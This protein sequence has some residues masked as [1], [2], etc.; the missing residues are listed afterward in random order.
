MGPSAG[1]S[2]WGL[3]SKRPQPI[4]GEGK[5]LCVRSWGIIFWPAPRTLQHDGMI[6]GHETPGALGRFRSGWLSEFG[7]WD[8][9]MDQIGTVWDRSQ[10]E[11]RI[12]NLI[13]LPKLLVTN[14]K[15]ITDFEIVPSSSALAL[16]AYVVLALCLYWLHRFQSLFNVLRK[17]KDQVRKH[18]FI[19]GGN[20]CSF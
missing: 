14:C 9:T 17:T 10:F 16:M 13:S 15:L 18:M 11:I 7:T 12:S 3:S 1:K 2:S 6:S 4:L 8:S 19:T 20:A 5:G